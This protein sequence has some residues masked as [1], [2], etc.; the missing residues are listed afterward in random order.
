MAAG[1]RLGVSAGPY[2]G[3]ISLDDDVVGLARHGEAGYRAPHLIDHAANVARLAEAGCDR[4]LAIGSVGSLRRDLEVG[5]FVAPDD[6]IALHVG[7]SSFDDDRGHLVA[8]FDPAWRDALVAAWSRAARE[9]LVDGGVYWQAIG[10]RFETAAE[11]RLMAAHAD[12]VGMT[13]GSECV[14]AREAGLAHAAVCVVDNLANGI[15]ERPLSAAEV[16]AGQDRNR[17]RLAAVVGALVAELR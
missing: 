11:I 4:V 16:R 15:G 7:A 3:G 14:A 8:G 6:F 10:P 13:L 2:L 17:R 5:S 12:V 1:G 9:R